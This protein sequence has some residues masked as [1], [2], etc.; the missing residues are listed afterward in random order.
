MK[1]ETKASIIIFCV[2]FI[3]AYVM[4]CFVPDEILVYSTEKSLIF[5]F[6]GDVTVA[7]IGMRGVIS[8]AIALVTV[9]LIRIVELEVRPNTETKKVAKEEKKLKNKK[10]K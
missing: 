5:G 3:L 2:T 9:L 4:M 7:L 6:F 8:L 10:T 1:K